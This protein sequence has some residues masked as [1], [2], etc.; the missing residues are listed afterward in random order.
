M[1]ADEAQR[2]RTLDSLVSGY[3]SYADQEDS[4]I[5]TQGEERGRMRTIGLRDQ[6]LGSLDG[7][8]R[9]ILDRIHRYDD[10]FI[11]DSLAQGKDEGRQDA[12]QQAM[13][14]VVQLSR[15]PSADQRKSFLNAQV[16]AAGADPAMK[17]FLQNLQTLS[18]GLK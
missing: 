14:V 6:F 13:T 15:Q 1:S 12:L 2:L 16:Q 17:A 7:V 8:F 3:R 11:Q 18:A 4:I 5:G 9:G 10:R